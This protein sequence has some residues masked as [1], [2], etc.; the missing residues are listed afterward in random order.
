MTEA[1]IGSATHAI[2]V[3]GI[4]IEDDAGGHAL[5]APRKPPIVP[6]VADSVRADGPLRCF[7]FL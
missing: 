2:N 6:L 3:V 5:G 1:T 4:R 7:E